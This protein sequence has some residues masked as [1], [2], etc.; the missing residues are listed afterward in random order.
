[1]KYY[2]ESW[3]KGI[4]CVQSKEGWL[5]GLVRF[6][7]RGSR[8]VPPNLHNLA[9]RG[10]PEANLTP[11]Q[12]YTGGKGCCYPLNRL[13]GAGLLAVNNGP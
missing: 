6:F 12:L 5:T 3:R 7:V 10:R 2:I 11:R 1:M 4:S 8:N 13:V 9:G